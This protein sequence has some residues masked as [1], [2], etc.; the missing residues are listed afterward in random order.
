M[1]LN[2]I[3]ATDRSNGI[4]N[5]E[6]SD[7][8]ALPWKLAKEFE[9]FCSMIGLKGE[10]DPW[11]KLNLTLLYLYWCSTSLKQTIASH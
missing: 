11:D 9:Y 7:I 1:I 6:R 5:T 10:Q 8:V 4:G 3:V 2:A